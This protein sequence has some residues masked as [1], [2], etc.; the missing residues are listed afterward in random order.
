MYI[1]LSLEK[2]F[3]SKSEQKPI[4]N[5][6]IEIHKA[7]LFLNKLFKF[8]ISAKYS[9]FSRQSGLSK[10]CGLLHPAAAILLHCWSHSNSHSQR[11]LHLGVAWV[12]DRIS[13]GCRYSRLGG[14]YGRRPA[15]THGRRPYPAHATGGLQGCFTRR[16][17]SISKN[18]RGAYSERP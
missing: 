17:R 10:E 14:K 4:E 15:S 13:V 1:F 8:R 12:C 5:N 9:A 11:H 2:N 18:T 16:V 6:T 7:L 3:V